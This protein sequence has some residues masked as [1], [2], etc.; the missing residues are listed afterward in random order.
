M[1]VLNILQ[2]TGVKSGEQGQAEIF[3]EKPGTKTS[4]LPG[5]FT[6]SSQ[7]LLPGWIRNFWSFVS[8]SGQF[9]QFVSISSCFEEGIQV[10]L[11]SRFSKSDNRFHVSGLEEVITST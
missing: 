1:L 6:F 2:K 8:F 9:L 4:L 11:T 3:F 10:S 7:P 5:F